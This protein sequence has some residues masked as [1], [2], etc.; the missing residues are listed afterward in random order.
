M[1]QS[2]KTSTSSDVKARPRSAIIKHKARLSQTR[3]FALGEL[4]QIRQFDKQVAGTEV[5]N[6]IHP[7]LPLN[8]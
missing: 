5:Y 1:R 4:A 6:G 2:I 3:N 8:G 7:G